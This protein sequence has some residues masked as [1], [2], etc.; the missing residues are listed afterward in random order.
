MNSIEADTDVD[1]DGLLNDVDTDDDNDGIEDAE[2]SVSSWKMRT[3]LH[4]IYP[5][6]LPCQ[7]GGG[8]GRP[9]ID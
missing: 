5:G 2:R 4:G 3:V 9:S 6:P 1:G 8:G 7:V